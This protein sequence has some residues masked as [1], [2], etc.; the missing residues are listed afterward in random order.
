MSPCEKDSA[1]QSNRW[2]H[3]EGTDVAL[4]L[5]YQHEGSHGG[6]AV[7]ESPDS[8]VGINTLTRQSQHVDHTEE[9]TA[10]YRRERRT[11]VPDTR[12]QHM[13]GV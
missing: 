3:L 2:R 6:K 1:S 5:V 7:L 10:N 13:Q 12:S 8:R 4:D 9:P 11:R